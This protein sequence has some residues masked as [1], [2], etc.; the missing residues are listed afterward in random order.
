MSGPASRS[1][2]LDH[3]EVLAERRRWKALGVVFVRQPIVIVNILQPAL[4]HNLHIP[5]WSVQ[6]TAP[7]L[8]NLETTTTHVE[9]DLYQ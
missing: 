2:C 6:P 7:C 8:M 1:I 4:F 9:A 3:S 5:R